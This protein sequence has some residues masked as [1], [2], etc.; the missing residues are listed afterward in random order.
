MIERIRYQ[1]CVLKSSSRLLSYKM[2]FEVQLGIETLERNRI[3]E[4]L[5]QDTMKVTDCYDLVDALNYMST[6]GWEI[7]HVNYRELSGTTYNNPEYLMKRQ[8]G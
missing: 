1:Y 8:V 2:D 5:K 6:L 3:S 7:V 4:T